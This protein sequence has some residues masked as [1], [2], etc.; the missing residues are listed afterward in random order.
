MQLHLLGCCIPQK[1][2]CNWK[3]IIPVGEDTKNQLLSCPALKRHALFDRIWFEK[4]KQK[5]TKKPA[6]F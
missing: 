1:K 5:K 3:H 6:G 2:F 4:K